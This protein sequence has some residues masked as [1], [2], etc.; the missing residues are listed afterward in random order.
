MFHFKY[1]MTRTKYSWTPLIVLAISGLESGV[2]FAQTPVQIMDNVTFRAGLGL[3]HDDNF[4]RSPAATAQSEQIF[5]QSVGLNVSIPVSL[6]RFEFDVGFT[7]NKYREFSNFDY[8]GKNYSAAWRWSFTP[9]LH[10][11]LTSSRVET[12]NAP[13]E[14]ATPTLRNTNSTT[15]NGFDAVY[16]FG[17]PWQIL[18]GYSRST[19]L[20]E[21]AL[22]GDANERTNTYNAG[23]RY[24][25]SSGNS[26]AYNLSHVSG[27]NARDYKGQI[28][29]FSGVW[30][31]SG[32]TSV[33][34]HVA[35]LNR[36]YS[37]SPQF[38]YDGIAGG[39]RANW[40]ATG[41]ITL[42]ASWD[43][44][45]ASYQTVGSTHT[46]TDIL[47]LAPVWQISPI[48]SMRAQYR[49]SIRRDK[50]NPS[51]IASNR[52]D[53]THDMSLTYLWQPRP[54]VS[55]SASLA[56]SKRSSNLPNLGY[57]DNLVSV[58]AD[59]TF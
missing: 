4:F 9:Q 29:D 44:E 13:T 18:A 57:T 59:F 26:L 22:I 36:D 54:F 37:Q 49:Y 8:L 11:N 56:R 46:E 41:K 38:D 15:T 6:Q 43:R 33:T 45:L 27:E 3:Q 21:Q 24:L 48:T 28:H 30:V 31:V 32:N 14:S 17:G 7:N 12:L 51:G 10:G 50:G 47:T 35:Y 19:S 53:N 52:K 16:E 25:L 23:V 1:L 40:R 34:G 39:I 20:N 55:L 2:A 5:T 58:G 42:N